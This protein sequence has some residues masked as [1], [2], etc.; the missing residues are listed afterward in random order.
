MC[1][2]W[3]TRVCAGYVPPVGPAGYGR[4]RL[5]A[6]YGREASLLGMGERGSLLGIHPPY[7][8]G[9][10]PSLPWYTLPPPGYTSLTSRLS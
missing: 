10:T 4:E 6:G 3:N 1:R 9:Y 5:P 8:A 7:H 2:V